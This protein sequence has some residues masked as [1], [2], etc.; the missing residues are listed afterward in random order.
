MTPLGEDNCK[1]ISGLSPPRSYVHFAFT[2][3]NLY[4]FIVINNNHMSFKRSIEFEIGLKDP[5][6]TVHKFA[7]EVVLECYLYKA[8]SLNFL[9]FYS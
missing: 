9:F 8:P 3:F 1:V 5:G 7:N 6:S 4:Y 2:H